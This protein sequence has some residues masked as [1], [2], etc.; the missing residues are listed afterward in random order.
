MRLGFYIDESLEISWIKRI[1]PDVEFQKWSPSAINMS[2]RLYKEKNMTP[3]IIRLDNTCI[4]F[5]KT[6]IMYTKTSTPFEVIHLSDEYGTDD[7]S[8]YNLKILTKIYRNYIYP[9]KISEFPPESIN[10]IYL[11]PL[12]PLIFNDIYDVTQPIHTRTFLWSFS[13]R[14]AVTYR[15][16]Q[17]TSYLDFGPHKLFFYNNFMDE[18][19]KSKDEYIE[20]L[21][22]SKCVAILPGSNLETYRLY[23]A[24]EFGAIPI[25]LRFTKD[26]TLYFEFLKKILPELKDI[27]N[28]KDI[29]KLSDDELELYR[30]KLL[31]S[32]TNVKKNPFVALSEFL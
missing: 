26:D 4:K 27:K 21:L 30:Q 11:F 8:W 22:T 20:E 24:L 13:G 2:I 32:W 28:P 18:K 14:L 9:R 25:Y 29:F 19:R 12:G 3:I 6:T 10:K 1:F 7:L 5:V 31:M 23:E 17:I 15:N 16:Y